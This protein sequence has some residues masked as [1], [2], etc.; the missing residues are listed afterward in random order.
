[1]MNISLDNKRIVLFVQ[2]VLLIAYTAYLVATVIGDM[3]LL[4]VTL[5]SELLTVTVFFLLCNLVLFTYSSHIRQKS[6]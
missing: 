5:P 4:L 2:A 1:M 3:G 6:K